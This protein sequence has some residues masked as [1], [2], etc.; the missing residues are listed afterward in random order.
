MKKEQFKELL[1]VIQAFAEGKPIQY[2]SNGLWIDINP[3][4][5][6][7]FN[8]EQSFRIK[9]EQHYRPFQNADECWQEMLKHKPFGWLINNQGKRCHLTNV[10]DEYFRANMYNHNYDSECLAYKFVDGTPFGI[11]D[12]IC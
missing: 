3:E 2:M 10:E 1:P 4:A 6:I 11:I 7:T 5:N 9:P 8:S 12:T